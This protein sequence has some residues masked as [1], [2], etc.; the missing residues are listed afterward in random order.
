MK[1]NHVCIGKTCQSWKPVYETKNT[2]QGIERTDKVIEGAGRCTSG[3][4]GGVMFAKP[5]VPCDG[6]AKE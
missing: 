3:S 4:D 2:H 5:G 6:G 1:I